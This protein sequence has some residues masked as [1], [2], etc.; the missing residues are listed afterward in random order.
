MIMM[1]IM[2]MMIMM[3]MIMIM[4]KMIMMINRICRSLPGETCFTKPESHCYA[5]DRFGDR[6][7]R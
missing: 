7:E 5:S 1:M 2:I 6:T 4:I 3:I